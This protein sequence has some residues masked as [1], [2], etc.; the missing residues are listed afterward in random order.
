M[1][2]TLPMEKGNS[3]ATRHSRASLSVRRPICCALDYHHSHN[4]RRTP[5][6]NRS[7]DDVSTSSSYWRFP[8]CLSDELYAMANKSEAGPFYRVP[9]WPSLSAKMVPED[10]LG[11]WHTNRGE[12]FRMVFLDL[13]ARAVLKRFLDPLLLASDRFSHLLLGG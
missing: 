4:D 2:V 3:I 13:V 9:S 1:S 10:L 6:A 7:A 8:S 5:W 11:I 12:I